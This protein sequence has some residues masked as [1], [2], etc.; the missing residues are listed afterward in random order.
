MI[1]FLR[2]RVIKPGVVETGG[3]GWAVSSPD[4]L[5]VGDEVAL[6]ITTIMREGSIA[7]YGF[8]DESA[9]VMF[10]ALCKV[11]RVGPS[12]ALSLLRTHSPG[13]IVS[14]VKSKD[15]SQLAKAPGL[16]KKT[17]EMI[18]AALVLPDIA[19]DESVTPLEVEVASTL[20]ELGFDEAAA[21]KVVSE[22]VTKGV[23]DEATLLREAMSVLRSRA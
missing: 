21:Q 22:L 10:E 23:S 1:G 16:G 19:A 18:C 13:Q 5:V 11:T 2:G 3:I 8:G 15:V 6:H 7:L 4:T 17:A 20:A 12:A 14:L 9:Q